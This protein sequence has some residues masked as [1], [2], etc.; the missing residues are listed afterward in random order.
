MAKRFIPP[1]GGIVSVRVGCILT[2][3]AKGSEVEQTKIPEWELVLPEIEY[4]PS[5]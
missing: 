2:R 1:E 3:I 4:F 5:A